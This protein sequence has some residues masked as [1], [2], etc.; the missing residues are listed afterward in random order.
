M[1]TALSVRQLHSR[2]PAC[3]GLAV[4]SQGVVLGSSHVLVRRASNGYQVADF[5][6][7][8]RPAGPWLSVR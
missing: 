2:G 5:G 1:E 7:A 4:D 3:R 6:A 8:E